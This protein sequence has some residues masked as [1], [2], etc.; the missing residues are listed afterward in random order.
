MDKPLLNPVISSQFQKAIGSY[1]VLW[2]HVEGMFD[3][4][5]LNLVTFPN[6]SSGSLSEPQ[7]REMGDAFKRRVRRLRSAAKSSQ[8]PCER[9]ALLLSI[10][11]RISSIRSQRDELAH[12]AF[13]DI[14]AGKNQGTPSIS[15][16]PMHWK[17][18]APGNCQTVIYTEK[19][20]LSSQR[21]LEQL[22]IDFLNYRLWPLET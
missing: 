20:L 16:I 3:V 5:Y 17:S 14:V 11:E 1:I 19:K 10:L 22:Y 12:T 8:M 9:K 18:K 15:G 7:V 6:R 4:T 2:S 13:T 21:K